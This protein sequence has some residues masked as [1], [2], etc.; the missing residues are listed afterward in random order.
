MFAVFQ[1]LLAVD[2]DILHPDR[3]LMRFFEGGAVA[4]PRRIKYHDI[5]EHPFLEPAAMIQTEVGSRQ[6]AQAADR[7][8]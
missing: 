1:D 4:D 2:E 3:V 6:R 7:F 8:A 5:G